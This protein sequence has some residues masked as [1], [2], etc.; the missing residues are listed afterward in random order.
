MI[1]HPLSVPNERISRYP[2]NLRRI[3]EGKLLT[4][5]QLEELTSRLEA[6][7][8]ALYKRIGFEAIKNIELGFTRP[9]PTTAR[10]IADALEVSVAEIFVSGVDLGFRSNIGRRTR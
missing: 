6:K 4:R 5:D 9:R 2:N 7:D 3:R 8:P 10:S 1:S